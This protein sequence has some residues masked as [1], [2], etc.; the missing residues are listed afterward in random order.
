MQRSV[1]GNAEPRRAGGKDS[2]QIK[3][4]LPEH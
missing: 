1:E 3:Y 2:R 4:H